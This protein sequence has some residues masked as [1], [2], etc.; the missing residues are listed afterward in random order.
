MEHVSSS[1][2]TWREA[3]NTFVSRS[4]VT[5]WLVNR[6]RCF[7]NTFRN[8][9]QRQKQ[10]KGGKWVEAHGWS[11]PGNGTEACHV[12]VT[13]PAAIKSDLMQGFYLGVPRSSH[14]LWSAAE[15]VDPRTPVCPSIILRAGA[16]PLHPGRLCTG[17]F[18]GLGS[19]A[20]ILPRMVH[21][22]RWQPAEALEHFCSI[23]CP[24]SPFPFYFFFCFQPFIF[25]RIVSGFFCPS[26]DKC[27]R[28]LYSHAQSCVA[29]GSCAQVCVCVEPLALKSTRWSL[30]HCQ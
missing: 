6:G 4:Q 28:P 29:V 20:F 10:A 30:K 18:S 1:Y 9:T 24:L 8:K 15:A 25:G 7:S 22:T 2:C 19:P 26:T 5:S 27:T 12:K 3:K 23:K 17:I 14:I 13:N 11:F 16:P 21:D